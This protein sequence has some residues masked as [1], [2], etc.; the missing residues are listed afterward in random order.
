MNQIKNQVRKMI[1]D[2]LKLDAI[3]LD[4]IDCV[5]PESSRK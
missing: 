4:Y 1:A 3:V 5:V 2:G